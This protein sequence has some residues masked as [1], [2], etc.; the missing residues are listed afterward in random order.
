MLNFRP[1]TPSDR[2]LYEG[3]L[4][5]SERRGCEY[6]FLNVFLWGEQKFAETEGCLVLLSRFGDYV[7][8]SYPLG[9]GDIKAAL[10]K[11]IDDAAERGT[12]CRLNGIMPREK[13]FI[14]KEFPERFSFSTN[15]DTYDYIYDIEALSTLSGKKYHSKR[16]FINRFYENYPDAVTEILDSEN[17]L[18]ALKMAEEWFSEKEALLGED[19]FSLEKE[20]IRRLADS[21]AELSPEGLLLKN[22]DDILAFTVGT[23]FYNDTF[24]V[25]FEKALR[26]SDGAYPLINREFA[27][28]IKEKYPEVKFLDREEDMGLEGLRKAKESYRPLYNLEKWRA[29]L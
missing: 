3:Y 8:Y 16:N 28:H 1:I 13:E 4:Q 7:A 10:Q 17:I 9:N 29:K 14:E 6:S 18:Q 12:P 11:I 27:R 19:T 2:P 5:K 15:R 21:F 26:D 24:D 25:H 22:G 23:H 20:A